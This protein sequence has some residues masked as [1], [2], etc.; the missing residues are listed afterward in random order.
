MSD[1]WLYILGLLSL[2][3]VVGSGWTLHRRSKR[4]ALQ[5]TTGEVVQP[6]RETELRVSD[7]QV[8]EVQERAE[9]LARKRQSLPVLDPARPEED[10]LRRLERK[11][12]GE[13]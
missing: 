13:E 5:P 11:R 1:L 10:V 12:G 6:P 9:R 4:R 3:G 7:R 2:L 8:V